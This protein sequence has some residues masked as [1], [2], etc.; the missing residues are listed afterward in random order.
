MGTEVQL[1]APNRDNIAPFLGR[2]R[3]VV[4]IPNPATPLIGRQ[5]EVATVASLLKG[6]GVRLLTLTGPGG[7]GKT[8]LALQVATELAA[9]GVFADGAAFV[10][11]AAVQD[12]GLVAAT[13]AHA[14]GVQEISDRPAGAT[15]LHT[16]APPSKSP[17]ATRLAESAARSRTWA[18]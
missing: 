4:G 16:V 10:P 5:A 9:D 13:I 15:W 12:P 6:D 7:V 2:E 11:L 14:L 3:L 1:S 17:F 18:R 8:R